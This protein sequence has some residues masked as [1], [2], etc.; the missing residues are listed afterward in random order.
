MVPIKYK[1]HGVTRIFDGRTA[2]RIA[3]G[4]SV[5]HPGWSASI[6]YDPASR[7]FIELSSGPEGVRGGGPDAADRVDV[8]YVLGNFGVSEQD[9]LRLTSQRT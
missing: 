3:K 7:V 8:A 5:T 2:V 6:V 9:L 4:I 1:D